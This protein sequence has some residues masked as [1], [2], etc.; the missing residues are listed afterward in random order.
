MNPPKAKQGLP[1]NF[2]GALTLSK[3]K[4]AA[5]RAACFSSYFP[6]SGWLQDVYL[7]HRR[8]GVATSVAQYKGA[9]TTQPKPDNVL[10]DQ[11]GNIGAGCQIKPTPTRTAQPRIITRTGIVKIWLTNNTPVFWQFLARFGDF[12]ALT[13]RILYLNRKTPLNGLI[14]YR[15]IQ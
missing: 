12:W 9:P 10:S 13:R 8:A 5:F 1:P 11:C 4:T 2:V 3:G 7:S 14:L 6:R 15:I